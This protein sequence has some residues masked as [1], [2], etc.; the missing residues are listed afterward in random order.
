MPSTHLPSLLFHR[1]NRWQGMLRGSTNILAQHFLQAGYPVTWLGRPYHAGHVLFQKNN[2][3]GYRFGSRV[4][5]SSDG[6]L[7]I[8][9]FTLAPIIKSARLGARVWAQSARLGYQ[10]ICPSLPRLMA[11]ASQPSPRIIW[12]TGGD[13]DGLLRTFPDAKRIVQCVDVYEAYAGPA[14]NL[15]EQHDYRDADAIVAI[16]EALARYLVRE[17]QVPRDKIT[18]IGQGA[19]L[20]LFAT[21]KPEPPEVANCLRP[22]LIWVGLLE[23]ADA[24]LME[25][26]LAALPNGEGSLVLLGPEAEWARRLATHDQRVHVIGPRSASVVAACLQHADVGLMLYD[27]KRD[28]RQYEGQNPLKLYEMAAAGL[29]IISTSHE[30]YRYGTNPALIADTT[31]EVAAAMHNALGLRDKLAC[32]SREF[33]GANGWSARFVQARA[34]V[35][36]LLEDHAPARLTARAV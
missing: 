23:K 14:Q 7:E 27:R 35:H 13:A 17:R 10:T 28:P 25:A 8:L 2:S 21:L 36:A 34:L 29:P 5:R 16:G 33:A 22:R 19:D 24:T 31:E 15:L 6:A 1:G 30:E 26:A 4:E 11:E 32:A 3:H 9:P 12:S 18:V 20:E